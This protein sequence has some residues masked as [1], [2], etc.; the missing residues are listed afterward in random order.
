MLPKKNGTGLFSHFKASVVR[1]MRVRGPVT[2]IFD[3]CYNALNTIHL[4]KKIARLQ[5][6]SGYDKKLGEH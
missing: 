5:E 6:Y 4:L 3:G 1:G 2:R